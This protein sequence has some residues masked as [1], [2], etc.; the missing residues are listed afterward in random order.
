M[1]PVT[2]VTADVALLVLIWPVAAVVATRQSAALA[3]IG[4][5]VWLATSGALLTA[6]GLSLHSVL[7]AHVVLASAALATVGVGRASR[8]MFVDPLDAIAMALCLC[9]S[10]SLGIFFTGRFANELSPS[11]L[12]ALLAANPL[13]ASAS[14]ASIDIFHTPLLYRAS[15][16]GHQLFDY[17][18]WPASSALFVGVAI[19]SVAFTCWSTRRRSWR[20]L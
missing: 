12:S 7:V 6:M 17:P 8:A 20:Q 14:A 10:A 18:A 15:P 16:I 2:V 9:C 5:L 4:A 3:A 19:V 11:V 1:T 13:V